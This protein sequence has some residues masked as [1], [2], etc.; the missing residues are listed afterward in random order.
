L[1]AL[2]P[3]G[4]RLLD[5]RKI[6]RLASIRTACSP[7]VERLL[8]QIPALR[9]GQEGLDDRARQRH[10]VAVLVA[11][12]TRSR[13]HGIAEE[14]RKAGEF[15]FAGKMK[16]PALLI[17]QHVLPKLRSETRELLVDR[18]KPLLFRLGQPGTRT[19]K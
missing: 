15:G 19:D 14:G 13:G 5:D 3:Q 10:D 6:V 1:C 18:G 17:R 7:C 12:V 8:P 16:L 4:K 2:D 11:A 9:K